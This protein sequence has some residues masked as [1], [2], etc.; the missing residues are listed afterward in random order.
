MAE[1]PKRPGPTLLT[2]ALT[3]Q[4][5]YTA[6]GTGTWGILR[7]IT[8]V[9]ETTSPVSVTVGIGTSNTDAAGKRIVKSAIVQPGTDPFS[10]GGFL[11]I[12]GGSTP[13]LVYAV[14]DTANGATVTLGVVEGP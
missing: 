13:D 1:V 11:P 9:N 10:W 2:T 14:C 4:T 3:S 12:I 6:P 7:E 5:I 8:I